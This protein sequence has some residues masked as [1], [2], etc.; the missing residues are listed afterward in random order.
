[1][2]LKL[3]AELREGHGKGPARRLRADGKVPATVYGHGMEPL[4]VAVDARDLFHILHTDAGS[5]VLIDLE[6]GSDNHL[7]L[8]REIQRDHVKGRFVHVDFLAVRR[9]VKITV[10]VP[11]HLVGESP[12]VKEGG[13]IE[14]QT[15]EVRA[16]CLPGDVPE[17]FEA[18]ISGLAI[19]DSVRVSDLRAPE[20]VEILSNLDDVI[21][22][23]VVPAI[24]RVE[25]EVAEEELAEAVEGA[26]AVLEAEGATEGEAA[27]HEAPPGTEA[28]SGE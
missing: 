19:G 24:L 22:S 25:E 13:V 6:V 21:A 17:A 9:D 16:Q 7:T 18:D 5:N 12:G 3:K 4:S 27:E 2:E 1:M 23:V 28:G 15:W 26:E 20:G 11:V 14:H 8:P 10:D